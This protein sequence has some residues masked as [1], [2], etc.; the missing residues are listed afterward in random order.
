MFLS[1]LPPVLGQSR[2]PLRS[3]FGCGSRFAHDRKAPQV[4]PAGPIVLYA[5]CAGEKVAAALKLLR[6]GSKPKLLSRMARGL[7]RIVVVPRLTLPTQEPFLSDM[8]PAVK[9]RK[10]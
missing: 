7:L 8:P 9:K 1:V 3:G 10:Y 6:F 4:K 2:P 5:K